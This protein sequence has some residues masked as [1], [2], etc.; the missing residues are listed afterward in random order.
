VEKVAQNPN[1]F[2][3]ED[4][5]ELNLLDLHLNEIMLSGE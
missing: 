1:Y 2:N 4:A 3:Q 5:A